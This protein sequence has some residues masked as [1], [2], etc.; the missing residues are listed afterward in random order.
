MHVIDTE[1]IYEKVIGEIAAS[2]DKPYPW[3]V[4][5]SLLGTTEMTTAKIAVT[6]LGLPITVDEFRSQF[7]TAS[8]QRLGD[9]GMMEGVRQLIDSY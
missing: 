1:H 4:R 5:V 2:Y 9:V 6:E 7:S 8:R 3:D